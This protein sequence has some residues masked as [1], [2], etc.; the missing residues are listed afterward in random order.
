MAEAQHPEKLGRYQIVRELGKGAMGIVYEGEDPNIG[1]RV[2]IKTAR[3]DVMESSGL[4][5]EMMARFLREARA[6]GALSH[7]HI[8][9][10]YDADEQDGIA[11]IAMEF[12]DGGDLRKLLEAR[13][14]HD[15]EEIITLGAEICEA[16]AFAHDRGIVHR[17]VKPAN[18][19]TPSSGGFKIADFGIAHVE[20]SNLTQDGAMIGT[21]HYMSPEQF[22][23]Q[24]ID[25]RSDLFSVAIILYELLTGEKPFTGGQLNTI[26]HSV[27]KIDPIPPSDLNMSIPTA[28]SGVLMKALAKRPHD[29]YP[30]GRAMAAALRESMKP[31][32]NPEVLALPA[33]VSPTDTQRFA[34]ADSPTILTPEEPV[35]GRDAAGG[36]AA[37][38]PEDAPT[39]LSSIDESA[40][41]QPGAPGAIPETVPGGAGPSRM[42][43]LVYAGGAAAVALLVA[44]AGMLT[45]G[46]GRETP[47]DPGNAA[48][49]ENETHGTAAGDAP[50]YDRAAL[51]IAKFA[52][53]ESYL[54]WQDDPNAHAQAADYLSPT[55]VQVV[56]LDTGEVAAESRSY[57]SGDLLRLE[58]QPRRLEFRVFHDDASL[59]PLRTSLTS[60]PEAPG[61]LARPSSDLVLIP[62]Q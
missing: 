47:E 24:R 10:V 36:T 34:Q 46:G 38:R 61:S 11:Y 43:G 13:G 32:P 21:P 54:L 41:E 31:A 39:V 19:L 58:G 30:D 37:E 16:L 6:A 15:P 18:I 23:G 3:R 55:H 2:A 51:Q 52:D 25:G 59:E 26:M 7:P 33:A 48:A 35:L 42:P 1:R 40:E 44:V 22:V 50:Y 60:L 8:I 57:R 9:T 17:D 4:A 14:R 56:D 28:L 45:L 62:P 49:G 12:L 29:R 53:M 5:D 27:M 20:D